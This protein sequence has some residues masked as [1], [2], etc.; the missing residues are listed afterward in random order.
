MASFV[1]LERTTQ[2]PLF[3]FRSDASWIV[4]LSYNRETTQGTYLVLSP[5]GAIY[6]E[7]I[8]ADGTI[9]NTLTIKE[10]TVEEDFNLK[11]E[12]PAT[13]TDREPRVPENDG[14]MSALRES[15]LLEAAKALGGVEWVGTEAKSDDAHLDDFREILAMTRTKHS[16]GEGPRE[17][18]G[19]YLKG[20]GTVVCHTGTSPNSASHARIIVGLLNYVVS[21]L[22]EPE[23]GNRSKVKSIRSNSYRSKS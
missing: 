20:T 1:G 11:Q 23:A 19:V 6:R 2:T 3:E 13:N 4:W 21:A 9:T 15:G 17:M 8:Q 5:S 18:H 14:L 12:R 22:K 16:I 10:A 7:T